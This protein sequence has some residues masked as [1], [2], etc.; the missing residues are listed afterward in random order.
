MQLAV[1]A[2]PLHQLG[3]VT[4]NRASTIVRNHISGC[5]CVRRYKLYTVGLCEHVCTCGDG[6]RSTAPLGSQAAEE[7][8]EGH[9][10]VYYHHSLGFLHQITMIG[11]VL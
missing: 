6:A 11:Y 5:V 8:Q 2:T 9:R 10:P 1:P 3:A 4:V 7:T